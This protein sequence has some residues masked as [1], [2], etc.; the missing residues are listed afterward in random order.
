ML[1]TA[2]QFFRCLNT[3]RPMDINEHY[4]YNDFIVDKLKNISGDVIKKILIKTDF[5]LY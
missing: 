4:F 5:G 1:N 2:Q 3:F